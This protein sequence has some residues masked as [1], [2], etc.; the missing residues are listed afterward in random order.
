MSA[1]NHFFQFIVRQQADL[2]VRTIVS[3]FFVQIECCRIKASD[4]I[5]QFLFQSFY[6][7]Q[8]LFNAMF[9]VPMPYW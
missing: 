8:I 3:D 2:F 5:Q 1:V 4:A 7:N 9:L 6:G